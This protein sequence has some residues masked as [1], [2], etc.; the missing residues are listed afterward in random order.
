MNKS[1]IDILLLLLCLL[2]PGMAQNI[3]DGWNKNRVVRLDKPVFV[4]NNWSAYDELSDNIP[5][6]EALAMKELDHVVRLKKL[7][8]QVD[9]YMMDA[10]WFDVNEGYR[11]WRQ[12]CWPEGPERWLDACKREGIKPGLWFSTNLLRI[13]GD[14][15]TMKV[16]PEWEGSV[17]ED[18]TTLCLFRGGYL[19]HLMQTLQMYVDMGIKMFK[20]D[21]AYFDAATADVKRTMLPAEI[22]EQNKAVFISAIK[23]FRYKNP[24][25]LFIGYNGF[26]GEMEN[27]VAP[28]RKTVDLRWLE[29]FDTMYCGDPRLSDVPMMNFWRSQDLYS[30][31]MT[32]QYLFNGLP[33]WR[34][35]NCAF[36]IGTTGTCYNR[37]LN[38][39]KGMMVLSMAR[40]GW[41][42]VCHGNIDLLSD[43]DARWMADV[44]RLYMKVQQYGNF[45]AFGSIP[46][47][48]MPYGYMASVDGG[49]L[50]TVV[51]ASQEKSKIILPEAAGDGRVLFTDSGF[52]PVLEKDVVELG[53][54]QMAVIGYGKFNSQEYDLGIENDIIIPMAI[55]KAAID[56]HKKGEHSLTAHYT[57]SKGKNV[58]I[59]FRQL[60]GHGKAFRSWGGAP[61]SGTKMDRFFN[62]EVK[63]G[64]RSVPVKKSHDKMIWCG[65]SWAAGEVAAGDINEGRPLEISC[66]TID[67]SSEHCLLEVYETEYPAGNK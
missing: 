38:A 10:F 60:D 57:P 11:K 15:N 7:G 19:K 43:D 2:F 42:N 16:I 37:A 63:Q 1:R 30:D 31:H 67:G 39:W 3:S 33:S 26:G 13:G 41:L 9:Y 56:V 59:I 18:G 27:T 45:S 53:P 20:F 29:I 64:K 24:D 65:L 62:I 52:A 12:D 61:P 54:E 5:L 34:I 49:K 22:E 28:F 55:Q 8:V 6:D 35:D 48:A 44:Q 21:F 58:R 23:E 32:F 17:S 14:A 50:Y 40:G 4:Y 36:M 51:N 46:G 66:T 25:V 47:K